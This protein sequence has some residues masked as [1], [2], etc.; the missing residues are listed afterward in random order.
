MPYRT[1]TIFVLTITVFFASLSVVSGASTYAITVDTG[2]ETPTKTVTLEGES[3]EVSGIAE[4]RSGDDL[5]VSVTAP[6]GE[7]YRVY[8]YNSEKEIVDHQYQSSGDSVTFSTE[9]YDAGTYSLALYMDGDY[10]AIYPFVVEAADIAITAPDTATVGE[11]LD[12]S[13]TVESTSTDATITDV[14]MVVHG[15]ETTKRKTATESGGKYSTTFE[16]EDMQ[17]GTYSIYAVVKN[18]STTANGEPELIGVSGETS[19]TLDDPAETTATSSASGGGQ[20]DSPTTEAPGTTETETTTSSSPT[21]TALPQTSDSTHTTTSLSTAPSTNS[22]A[23]PTTT[24][25]TTA[26]VITP[27]TDT[28]TTSTTTPVFPEA[29][30]GTIIVV[31]IL[32]RTR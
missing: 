27:H 15:G 16:T 18:D 10:Q 8:I 7:S 29:I 25:G 2:L 24:A 11:D 23:N 32:F 22:P 4:V 9:G 12:V 26:S 3:F 1:S 30:I 20:D 21:T 19:V 5:P 6:E 13:A 17:S 31:V 14:E 28:E